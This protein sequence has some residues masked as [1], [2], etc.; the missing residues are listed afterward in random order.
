MGELYLTFHTVVIDTKKK[1]QVI[2]DALCLPDFV[3]PHGLSTLYRCS[4]A[5]IYMAQDIPF[6]EIQFNRN[7]CNCKG[8]CA[9]V[10]P[11]STIAAGI[12]SS[13]FVRVSTRQLAVSSLSKLILCTLIFYESIGPDRTR[14][15]HRKQMPY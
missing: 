14:N 8:R 9:L 6:H 11:Y 7:C 13:N 5:T 15:L 12:R 1:M 4:L 3:I 10:S 2:L